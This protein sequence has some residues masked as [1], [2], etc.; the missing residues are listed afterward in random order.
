MLYT[1]I[2]N[3]RK[4]I[5][6]THTFT[7]L[8]FG[9]DK[10]FFGETENANKVSEKEMTTFHFAA[11]M[12]NGKSQCVNHTIMNNTCEFVNFV[13]NSLYKAI[14]RQPSNSLTHSLTQLVSRLVCI[15]YVNV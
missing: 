11:T 1:E 10:R 3:E 4:K 9:F 6:R 15:L 13:Y 2:E 12:A 14:I 8:F 5:T 7:L